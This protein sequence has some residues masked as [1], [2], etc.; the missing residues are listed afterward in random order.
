MILIL[1]YFQGKQIEL[2]EALKK[3]GRKY[4]KDVFYDI[5]TMESWK[6]NCLRKHEKLKQRYMVDSESLKSFKE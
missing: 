4:L 2:P 6:Q 3:E 5:S 1:N